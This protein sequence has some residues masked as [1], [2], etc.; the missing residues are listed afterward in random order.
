MKNI[1][2]SDKELFE[3]IGNILDGKISGYIKNDGGDIKLLKVE[4]AVV[5]VQLLGACVGCSKS[6]STI[7]NVIEKEIRRMI[8]P[9]ISVE[10]VK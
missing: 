8:H 5:Y 3:A 2:F 10:E 6:N 7:K 1:P 9:D 4:N